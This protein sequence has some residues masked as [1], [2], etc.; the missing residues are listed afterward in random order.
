MRANVGTSLG[1]LSL[2]ARDSDE[3]SDAKGSSSASGLRRTRLFTSSSARLSQD[4]HSAA[5]PARQHRPPDPPH[6]CH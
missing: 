4:R 5:K 3:S 1:L 6:H 2:L